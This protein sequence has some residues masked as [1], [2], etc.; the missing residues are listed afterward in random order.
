M[1]P[2]RAL[3][4]PGLVMHIG[5][6]SY[7]RDKLIFLSELSNLLVQSGGGATTIRRVTLMDSTCGILIEVKFKVDKCF[8]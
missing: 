8:E 2:V 3:L 7:G 4:G 6:I 5:A 1:P